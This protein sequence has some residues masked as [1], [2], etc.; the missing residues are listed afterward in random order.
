LKLPAGLLEPLQAFQIPQRD[1]G[2]LYEIRLAIWC[3][4]DPPEPACWAFC[5]PMQAFLTPVGR[6]QVFFTDV[7]RKKEPLVTHHFKND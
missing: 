5:A 4:A 7:R 6:G 3:I 2:N 1:R